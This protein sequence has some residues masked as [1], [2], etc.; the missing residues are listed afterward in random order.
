M[1]SENENPVQNAPEREEYYSALRAL[2][3]TLYDLPPI[4][5]AIDCR[6]GTG[7][8]TLGRFLAWRFNVS[9][10]ET[11]LFLDRSQVG[12]VHR[13]EHIEPVIRHR[14]QSDR[15]IIVEG[16]TSLKILKNLDMKADFH[17]LVQC[18]EADGSSV[19]DAEWDSYVDEFD[20]EK[21]ANLILNLPVLE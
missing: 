17:I 7:K 8:T 2:R 15:P 20:P 16:I 19:M 10:L 18:K 9:L 1:L 21:S 3:Q 4:I 14:M 11:D 12:F 5:V 6:A 13:L